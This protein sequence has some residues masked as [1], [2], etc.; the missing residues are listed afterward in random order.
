ML[1]SAEYGSTGKGS[2]TQRENSR[3]LQRCHS[4]QWIWIE[5]Q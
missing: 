3:V 2:A 5:S 4:R 1:T